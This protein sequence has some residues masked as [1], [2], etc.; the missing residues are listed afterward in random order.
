MLAAESER[1]IVA[2]RA[3]A[4]RDRHAA[5]LYQPAFFCGGASPL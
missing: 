4:D 2:A 3:A 5:V 1:R